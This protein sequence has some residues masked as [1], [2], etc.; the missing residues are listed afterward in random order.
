MLER[1]NIPSRGFHNIKENGK[2]VGFQVRYR[3]TYYRLSEYEGA[4]MPYG[5]AFAAIRRQHVLLRKLL[6]EA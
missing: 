4:D 5:G 1:A 3:S 2:I 6:G